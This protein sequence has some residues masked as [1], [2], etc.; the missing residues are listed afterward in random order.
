MD[1]NTYNHSVNT[2]L[3]AIV[4]AMELGYEKKQLQSIAVGTLLHDFGKVFIPKDLLLKP[5]KLSPK[6]FNIVQNHPYLGYTYLQK[7]LNI[8]PIALSIV[9][10]H[11][12]KVNGFG[13]PNHLKSRS[14]SPFAKIVAIC[15]VYEALTADRPYRKAVSPSE[16]LELLM[17]SCGTDF[18]LPMVQSFISRINPYPVGSVVKL[19]NKHLAIIKK[20]NPK[21]VLRPMVSVI[22][23]NRSKIKLMD[24]D[25][26][27]R[28]DIVIEGL[29]REAL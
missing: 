15:D 17:G 11:H 7:Q 8:D 10:Q 1:D 3:L 29:Y 19:S 20:T 27:K 22:K 26:M 5:G 23:E 6:E 9:L 13:Y 21:Y 12:E 28:F 18:D 24:L 2:T 16:A 4:L 25:L 14:I